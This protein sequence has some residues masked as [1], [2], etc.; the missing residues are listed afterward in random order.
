M[1]AS[2]CISAGRRPR[3]GP[4]KTHPPDLVVGPTRS[5]WYR[6]G[7]QAPHRALTCSYYRR[8]R[9]SLACLHVPL[10]VTREAR[11]TFFYPSASQH[12]HGQPTGCTTTCIFRHAS[13]HSEDQRLCKA[14]TG[15][16]PV[17]S[18]AGSCDRPGHC[19]GSVV[20]LAGFGQIEFALCFYSD[21]LIDDMT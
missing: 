14:G 5:A 6:V 7:L 10:L 15:K 13:K 3:L 21:I 17:A 12:T 11:V 9:A 19:Q 1:C 2:S 16:D 4:D 8:G 18:V 20:S